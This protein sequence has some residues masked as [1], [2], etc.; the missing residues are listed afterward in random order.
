MSLTNVLTLSIIK[1]LSYTGFVAW[2]NNN[3]AIFSEKQ[4]CYIKN[5]MHKK[6]VPDIIGFRKSDGKMI[7]IEIKTGKDKLSIWQENFI[8]ELSQ[9]GGISFIARDF[10]EYR[11]LILKHDI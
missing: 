9:A 11:R 4:G 3:G 8:S 2:R 7:A 1:D 6:G 5:P 10:D